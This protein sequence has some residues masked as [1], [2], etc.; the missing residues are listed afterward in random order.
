M[1][2]YYDISN[3]ILRNL[4][5]KELELIEKNRN[6][7]F[8][9]AIKGK[10]HGNETK[11][12]NYYNI[13]YMRRVIEI[14]N[15]Y[16]INV[17]SNYLNKHIMYMFIMDR[18]FENNK[19]IVKIGYTYNLPNRNKSL[20]SDFDCELYLIGLKEINAEEDEI[21]FHNLMKQ[22]KKGYLYPYSKQKKNKK[23]D[24]SDNNISIEK[25]E[26]YILHDEVIKEFNNYNVEL[27]NKLLLE[28]EKTRQ[29][30]IQSEVIKEQEKT[31]QIEEQ[32]K[33]K[34]IEE[35]EKTKQI[36]EQEKTKQL[37][38]QVKIEK[39]KTRQLELEIKKLNLES[40]NKTF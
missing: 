22:M 34:Q 9:D 35:K 25:Y 19:M 8:H 21:K 23:N 11:E 6:N 40:K 32:E 15:E 20:C 39:E 2:K 17:Y 24:I 7:Y 33:T 36:E 3:N 1:I 18:I 10:F 12:L 5:K 13:N 38:I 29:L 14:Y 26:L 37:K 31:K 27:H 30:E 16:R 4:T 28:K